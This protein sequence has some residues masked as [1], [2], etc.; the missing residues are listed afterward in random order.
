MIK[1]TIEEWDRIVMNILKK[2]VDDSKDS[3]TLEE[4]LSFLEIGM[5]REMEVN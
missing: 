1:K 5:R 3:Y 2:S 4:W